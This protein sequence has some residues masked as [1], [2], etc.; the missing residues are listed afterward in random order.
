VRKLVDLGGV[1]S[2]GRR[3]R[4]CSYSVQVGETVEIFVDG[5][6]L[7][8]YQIEAAAVVYRDAYLI[9]IDKPAGVETQ[10]TPARYKGTLYAALIDYLHDPFRP[11]QAPS[12][13][14]VQR[15]DRDTS[16][17]M[18]F[19]IHPLAH[20][21]LT[22]TFTG[23][24]ARKRYLA[25]VAGRM[26]APEGEFRSLLARNRATNKVKSVDKG[27]KEAV[28]SFRVLE[29]FADASLVE[30]EILT[31]RSH[32]IRVHF[33][34]SGHPLL[35]DERY[36]GP[37]DWNGYPVRRQMLHSWRLSLAHPVNGEPLE[38]EAPIPADMAGLLVEL[39]RQ[40]SGK[41]ESYD[42]S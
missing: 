23:R 8:P 26:S 30:V 5:L 33:A 18:V 38:L 2:G 39:R 13:G 27:G 14:M 21:G 3:T 12:L 25:V 6:P 37:G 19:S 9:A 10:P 34:E 11:Q 16:G 22:E 1:H 28:T 40:E 32:Q 4:R 29:A 31:G 17:V 42:L 15:L 20:R 35:G 41:P 7:E 36:D 24:Q